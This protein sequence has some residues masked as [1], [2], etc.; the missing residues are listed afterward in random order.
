MLAL[1][2]GASYVPRSYLTCHAPTLPQASVFAATDSEPVPGGRGEATLVQ[3]CKS[4]SSVFSLDVLPSPFKAGVSGLTGEEAE[5]GKAVPFAAF[6][7]RGC[8]P[9]AF[10][11]S[12]GWCVEGPSGHT[13]KDVS[14]VGEE[15]CEY[16]DAS[17][18]SV[19]VS[20]VTGT[21]ARS[22]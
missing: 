12:D 3:K 13:W 18:V 16:D 21:F 10:E 14:L 4:C 8:E 2:L 6:E 17:D 19:T 9:E 1:W 15:F 20:G 5:A 7:C 11:V 22:K